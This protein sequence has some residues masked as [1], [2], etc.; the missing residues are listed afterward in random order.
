MLELNA[1]IKGGVINIYPLSIVEQVK[2]E[3]QR[4]YPQK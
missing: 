3:K 2:Q 1:Q 4:N